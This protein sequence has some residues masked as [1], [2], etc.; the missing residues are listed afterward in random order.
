MLLAISCARH[1]GA[2]HVHPDDLVR[3]GPGFLGDL[4]KIEL[5]AVA[6]RDADLLAFK[7]LETGDA[8]ALQHE[9]RVRRL[10]I[11]RRDGLDRHVLARPRGEHRGHV[12]DAE[13]ERAAGE[14][15][16]GV[17]G[18]VAARDRDVDAFL[19]EDALLPAAVVHGMLARRQ[20]IGLETDLVGGMSR[21]GER[22][23]SRRNQQSTNCISHL[24]LPR[25]ARFRQA[26]S[27]PIGAD[28][29][30]QTNRAS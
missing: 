10:G 28:Y 22:C 25:P 5:V 3:I 11:E 27:V 4:G 21:G 29:R 24:D 13:I 19:G 20:P 17:A 23:G 6:R 2:V 8:G 18:A 12:G 16:Q 15:G 9:Q 26:K 7:P 30:V 1:R 14:L